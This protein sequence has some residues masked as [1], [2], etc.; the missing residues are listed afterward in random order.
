MIDFPV[1]LRIVNFFILKYEFL[2]KQELFLLN[3]QNKDVLN[4]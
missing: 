4:N 1:C 3:W 2:K